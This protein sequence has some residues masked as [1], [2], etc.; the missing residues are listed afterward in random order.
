MTPGGPLPPPAGVDPQG[1]AP[2][3]IPP[4][5]APG[6]PDQSA[7]AQG[8]IADVVTAV[9]RLG[10]KYP[11]TL[12]EVRDIMNAVTRMQPKILSAGP[13]PEPQTPPT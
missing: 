5:P 9:R 3:G 2:G 8:W 4:S 10:M 7:Q 1:A 6:V 13:A 12:P 11:D